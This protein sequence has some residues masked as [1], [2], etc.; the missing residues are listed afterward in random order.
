MTDTA[1]SRSERLAGSLIGTAVGDALGFLVEGQP[2]DVCS[3]YVDRFV[4][5]RRLSGLRR[6][7]YA[8]GQ[9]SDDT[10]LSRE[11]LASLVGAGG[12]DPVDFGARVAALFWEGRIVG[13]GRATEEAAMRL[14]EG[15]PWDEAGTPPPAAGNGSAMR[16]GPVGMCFVDPATLRR[17]A[18]DQ[19]RVTHTD[20][21]CSAGAVAIA[22]AVAAACRGSWDPQAVVAELADHAAAF[23]RGFSEELGRLRAW[24]HLDDSM[25]LAA[26]R[27]AGVAAEY[28]DGW[29]GISP[30]VVPSVLWAVFV[31]LGAESFE[32]AVLRAIRCGGDVDTTGAMA[33]AIAGARFGLA[34]IDPVLRE[35]LTDRGTWGANELI[36]L[37][38]QAAAVFAPA[39]TP[40][41]QTEG[42]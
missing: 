1:I 28:E 35:P 21:R 27:R 42:R 39:Q 41:A 11:L 5:P 30:F 32:G 4:R 17:V 40:S 20:P 6:G 18:H 29:P 26:I 8:Y 33:G 24:L 14:V 7:P 38:E 3:D 25:A 2:A 10:Q 12:F 13:R 9:Y 31:N 36:A 37:A 16:A 15:V 23:D 34:G 22:A 19:S